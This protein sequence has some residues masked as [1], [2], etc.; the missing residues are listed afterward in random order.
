MEQEAAWS[1]LSASELEAFIKAEIFA[2]TDGHDDF[3]FA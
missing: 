3:S 1:P 2:A